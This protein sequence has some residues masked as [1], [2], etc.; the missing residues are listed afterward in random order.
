ME[1]NFRTW[2]WYVGPAPDHYRCLKI[3]V[4]ATRGEVISDT[5]K[6]IPTCIPIP[7]TG[8]DDH[9]RKTANDL[10]H[11]LLKKTPTI[12][13]LDIPSARDALI[14]IAKLLNRD[15]TPVITPILPVISPPPTAQTTTPPGIPYVNTNEEALLKYYLDTCTTTPAATSKGATHTPAATSKGAPTSPLATSKGVTTSTYKRHKKASNPTPVIPVLTNYDFDT[16]LQKYNNI[17]KAQT[18]SRPTIPRTNLPSRPAYKL[19]IPSPKQSTY[20]K[21]PSQPIPGLRR[22]VFQHYEYDAPT[23]SFAAQYIAGTELFGKMF[24]MYDETG[25]K[26]SLDSLLDGTTAHVWGQS[27]SNELARIAQGLGDIKGNDVVDYILKSEVPADR[28]VTYANFIC[29]YRPLKSDPH[30]VRLTV[31]G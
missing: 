10:V 30:R 29:D 6:F 16:I 14:Q 2:G 15:T 13:A 28:I 31:G 1:D 22:N 21:H 18:S 7:E 5:V 3:Y 25:S 27:L 11:L 20:S 8:I 26:E 9:L 23:R 12:P 24:H 17:P 4:P 19:N